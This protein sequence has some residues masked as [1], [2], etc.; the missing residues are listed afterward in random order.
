MECFGLEPACKFYERF[1]AQTPED[2]VIYLIDES[3]IS[4]I[5]V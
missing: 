2:W 5:L 4:D 1:G 3:M